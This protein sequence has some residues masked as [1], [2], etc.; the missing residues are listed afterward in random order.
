[1]DDTAAPAPPS[2]YQE[3]SEPVTAVSW[4]ELLPGEIGLLVGTIGL[5]G[6]VTVGV[7]DASAVGDVLWRA[8]TLD[9]PEAW[10]VYLTLVVTIGVTLLLHEGV[11]AVAARLCGCTARFGRQGLSVHVRLRGGFLSRRSDALI[12]LAPAVVLT[13]VGL[14][15]L[16]IAESAF[17][18]AIV[19][20]AVVTNAAGIGSDLASVLALGRLPPG[21]LVYYG[22]DG[23]L[24]YEPAMPVR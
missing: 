11:H 24:A 7:R 20:T 10:G 1:M 3:P 21:T 19:V 22:E 17:G 12:T 5:F 4:L 15:L 6:G 2:G 16:V 8:A 23:H 13:V 9:T 18:A 14:P